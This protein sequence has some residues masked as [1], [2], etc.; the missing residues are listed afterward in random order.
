MSKYY[1]SEM[2]WTV[3]DNAVQ[4]LGGSGYMKD[5][6]AE[7]YL[8]DSRIT[9]IYE[10]TSQLQLVAAVRGVSSGTFDTWTVDHEKKQY[11]V[12]LLAELQQSLIDAKQRVLEAIAFVKSQGTS[13]LDLSGKR[14]VDAALTIIIG[15]LFLGQG[16]R[17][18][19]KQRVARRFITRELPVLEMNCRQ[20]LTGDTSAMD[21]YQTLAGPVP[22]VD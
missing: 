18:E 12:P 19:R 10:G 7:R 20:I 13:Y 15:H 3:A 4:V 5:Y 2:S 17:S 11:D 9:R 16:E 1:C 8:R 6:P 22:A 21:E 14:L